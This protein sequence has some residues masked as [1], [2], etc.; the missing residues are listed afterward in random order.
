VNRSHHLLVV[1][2]CAISGAAGG[3]STG[4]IPVVPSPLECSASGEMASRTLTVL[5]TGMGSDVGQVGVALYDSP[6]GFPFKTDQARRTAFVEI[7]NRR[8][9]AIFGDVGPGSYAVAVF[10]DENGNGKLDRDW[11]GFPAEPTAASNN[12]RRHIHTPAFE[13]ARFGMR[14]AGCLEIRLQ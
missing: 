5:I 2:L 8:S 10:H 14:D 7:H 11:F 9:L 12:P 3:S 6:L 4:S 13:E 1:L